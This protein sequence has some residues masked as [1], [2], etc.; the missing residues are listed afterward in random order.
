MRAFLL[1]LIPMMT[2]ATLSI[3]DSLQQ[4]HGGVLSQRANEEVAMGRRSERS[5]I[6]SPIHEKRCYSEHR[7]TS[8]FEAGVICPVEDQCLCSSNQIQYYLY[9]MSI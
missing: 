9:L 1:L 6:M 7:M 5:F 3:V 4:S 8:H 2:L